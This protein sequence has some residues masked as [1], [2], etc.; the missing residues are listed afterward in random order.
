MAEIIKIGQL[1]TLS[2]TNIHEYQ[3]NSKNNKA[4]KSEN[5]DAPVMVLRVQVRT[6]SV[7]YSIGVDDPDAMV[8]RI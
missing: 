1:I 4:V 6:G 5:R 7:K 8:H 2:D 3:L